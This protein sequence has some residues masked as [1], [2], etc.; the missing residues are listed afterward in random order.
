MKEMK[1]LATLVCAFAVLAFASS[2]RAQDDEITDEPEE[3]F[4]PFIVGEG[5]SLG[6]VEW[7]DV[8]K[9][10]SYTDG[11]CW[12]DCH[13]HSEPGL[14]PY[15]IHCIIDEHTYLNTVVGLHIAATDRVVMCNYDESA[16]SWVRTG[17]C[18]R[19]TIVKLLVDGKSDDDAIW[20]VKYEDTSA[21]GTDC[22]FK[23]YDSEFESGWLK[24]TGQDGCDKIYGSQEDDYRLEGEYCYA[25]E[26][27]DKIYLTDDELT[28]VSGYPTAHG[29]EGADYVYGSGS[30]D[31]VWGDVLGVSSGA[32]A[33]YIYGYGDN[34]ALV[35][36]YGD[37]RIWGG[38]G[39]DSIW[40]GPGS[41]IL[42][43]EN[44]NDLLYGGIDNDWLYGGDG[45]DDYCNGNDGSDLCD[46]ACETRVECE[47]Y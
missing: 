28:C 22:D 18:D 34:D 41:D 47:S 29:R 6:D 11:T 46:T 32:G 43:G 20:F 26:G 35:D 16:G 10:E 1:V 3:I 2:A 36:G 12:G 7:A 38:R 19:D 13:Y 45:T 9:E 37:D 25:F 24:M 4:W 17:Y 27:A 44:E 40:G 42:R 30:S 39:Y 31:G 14:P 15:E 21:S 33:D 8:E 23:E 5:E